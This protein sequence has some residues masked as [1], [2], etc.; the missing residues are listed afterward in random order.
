M[1]EPA[2][3]VY[4]VDDDPDV[5]KAIERLLESIGTERCYVLVAAASF[6]KATTGALRVVSCSTSRCPA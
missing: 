4:V 5:L 3:T 1:P 6:S 2:P